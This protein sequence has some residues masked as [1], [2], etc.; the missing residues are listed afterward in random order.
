MSE[1]QEEKDRVPQIGQMVIWH[2]SDGTALNALVTAIWSPVCINVVIVSGD[3]T[4]QDSYGRQTE[5]R[6]S[7]QH[8]SLSTVHG[9]YWRYVDEQANSYVAPMAV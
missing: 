9:Y 5:R 4:K 3:E 8:K 7:C 1:K 2:E 6:T